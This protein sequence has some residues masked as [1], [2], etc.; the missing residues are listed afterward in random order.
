MLRCLAA[1]TDAKH[2]LLGG[3]TALLEEL[4]QRL[5]RQIPGLQIAGRYAPPFGSWDEAEDAKIFRAINDSVARF[6]WVGLGCPKQELWIARNKERLPRGVY[7]AVGAAFAFHAG[8][9]RQSPRWLQDHG[10]EWLYRIWSEP[11]RLAGRY[12]RYNSLFL[13][14]LLRESI[15]GR[16]QH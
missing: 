16:D 7:L 1:T 12:F 9:V 15:L 3:S 2:F 14:Y 8:Q 11:R 6:V 5:V 13:F 4:T 10:L